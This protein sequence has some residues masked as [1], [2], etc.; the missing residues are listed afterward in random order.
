MKT[1]IF[2]YIFLFSIL[3]SL[4]FSIAC[5]KTIDIDIEDSKPKIVLN[6]EINPDSTIKVHISRSRH[7]L[8]IA[9]LSTLNDAEV[10]LYEDETFIGNLIYDA[11]IS[12]YCINYKPIQG[13][14][15]KFVVS[16]QQ[17]ETIN[18]SAKILE[19]IKP[20]SIDTSR[21]FGQYGEEILNAS[22]RFKDPGNEKN[23]YMLKLRSKYK[24]EIWDPDLI[25]ID[26]IYEGPDTTI[27]DI[28]QGGYYYADVIDPMYFSSNDLNLEDG[29]YLRSLVI[30][31]ELFDGKEYALKISIDA[32]SLP[33]GYDTSI[34]YIDFHT[35]SQDY[36]KYLRSEKKYQNSSGDP[37]SE[38]VMVFTNVEN[39]LGIL[40]SA[41]AHTDSILIIGQFGYY[42]E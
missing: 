2:K 22:I 19:K 38:P 39:G 21:S 36:Y 6:A 16:H 13:K 30:S 33:Y 7:I 5:E 3:A 9:N 24:A 41:H 26:T 12:C 17:F 35:I 15:Y 31:D 42:Y 8:D 10:K 29:D 28:S 11:S 37:F 23:Y 14:N 18:A 27:I 34:V 25:T 32:F 20:I 1:S 4:I 40:G